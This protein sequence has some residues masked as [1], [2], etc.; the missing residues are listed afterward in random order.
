VWDLDQVDAIDL[1]YAIGLARVDPAAHGK[2]LGEVAL[3]LARRPRTLARKGAELAVAEAAV[4]FDSASLLLGASNDPVAAPSPSDRR[5][6][7]RAWRDN[8]FLR[9]TLGSYVA[10][11]RVARQLLDEADV[12]DTVREKARFALEL[13]LDAVAP[14]NVPW[15]NPRAVK[16][17]YDTGGLSVGRGVENFVD[18]LIHNGG[19]PRQ[20]DGSGFEVG[21]TLA[22]TRGRVVFRN[23]LIELIAYEPQTETVFEQ[24]VLY[25][26]AWINK[27]YVLDLAPGRSFVEHAVRAGLTVFAISY[28]NPDESTAGLRL[29][30]YL[31][32]GVLAAH[33][34]VS[35]L[36]GSPVV[37]LVSVCIGGTLAAIA[38]GVLAA[39]GESER[40]GWATLNVALVDFGAPGGVSAFVD[41]DTI[42]RMERGASGRGTF[43]GDEIARPFNLMRTNEFFWNYVVSN[44]YMGRR[45]APFDILAWNADQLRLPARM[46]ADFLRTF[47]LENRLSQPG[48]FEIDGTAVDLTRVETPLYVLGAETDHIAPWRGAYRT[49]QLVAGP[50]RFVLTAGGHIAGMVNP[51]GNPK[52]QHFVGDVHPA[53]PDEWLAGARRVAGSWW[54]DWTAWATVRSGARVAPPELPDGE[55]APGSY[56]RG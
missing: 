6:A 8:P 32:D 1:Q 9:A 50:Q 3:A 21:R 37:N 20:F 7:D 45:P 5:F 24:P 15:L 26:P 19:R 31:R 29:D 35:E 44:W 49:T 10:S 41:A 11:S 54:E 40:V 17:A 39:R 18:D 28:R 30:D 48:G 47:Y 34:R 27:Y 43:S 56:V 36:T 4:A 53:D 2:A 51:P 52:A 14:S 46:H 23:D 13:A 25:S 16:E 33:E 42:E 38:L 12:S 55:P 22:A